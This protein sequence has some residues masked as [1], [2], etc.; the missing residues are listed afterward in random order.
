MVDLMCKQVL[1]KK[2]VVAKTSFVFFNVN[3]I[4]IIDN[5]SWISIHVYV[6]QTWTLI[7]ILLTLLGVEMQKSRPHD[8]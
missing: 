4:I 1:K 8:Y 5:Q 2:N 7:L 6:M 3:E